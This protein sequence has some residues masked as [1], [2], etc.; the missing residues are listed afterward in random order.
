MEDIGVQ[1]LFILSCVGTISQCSLTSRQLN[2]K[3]YEIVSLSGTFDRESHHIT[4]SF[5]DPQTGSLVGGRVRSLTVHTTCE[6]MLAEP[7]DCTF[8]REL[9]PRT[10]E[11]ELVVRRKLL[12][13]F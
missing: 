6:L 2:K 9:D 7:L 3:E 1:S 8:F 4:G 5:A 13:D 12:T 11:N 10:G